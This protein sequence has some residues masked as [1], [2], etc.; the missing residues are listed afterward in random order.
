[1]SFCLFGRKMSREDFVPGGKN[2]RR[3]LYRR[4]IQEE[5][6]PGGKCQGGFCNS[7]A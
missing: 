4:I 7:V 6:V 5:N 3:I 2:L 1:M